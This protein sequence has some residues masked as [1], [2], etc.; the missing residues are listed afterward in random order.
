M[1]EIRMLINTF[2]SIQGRS[3]SDATCVCY[4]KT[5]D[6]GSNRLSIHLCF[7]LSSGTVQFSRFLTF[8]QIAWTVFCRKFVSNTQE[9]QANFDLNVC[10]AVKQHPRSEWKSDMSRTLYCIHMCEYFL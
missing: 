4:F 9:N 6:L 5:S 8:S 2:Y 1:N 10:Y 7:K 3:D